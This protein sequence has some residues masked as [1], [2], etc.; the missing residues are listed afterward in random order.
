MVHTPTFLNKSPTMFKAEILADGV[1]GV[2]LLFVCV[3][4]RKQKYCSR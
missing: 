1:S 4:V 3:T 2:L